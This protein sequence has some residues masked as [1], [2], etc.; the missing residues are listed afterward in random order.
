MIYVIMTMSEKSKKFIID[1]NKK[2]KPL[3]LIIFIGV[4]IFIAV[5]IFIGLFVLYILFFAQTVPGPGN[6]CFPQSGNYGC[7]V[8]SLN[9][10]TGNLS[11]LL[12]QNTGENWT[13]VY[14]VFS[15]NDTMPNE[16]LFQ[17]QNAAYISSFPSGKWIP[18]NFKIVSPKTKGVYGSLWARYNSSSQS[19]NYV[20]IGSL[21]V[22]SRSSA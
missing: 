14:I 16:S 17:K 7:G 6:I 11:I 5:L 12:E 1:D 2:Q 19:V 8:P 4:V 10:T 15:T 22:K 9:F 3:S 21:E 18:I 20:E 13:M